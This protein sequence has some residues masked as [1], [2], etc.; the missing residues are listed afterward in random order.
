MPTATPSPALAPPLVRAALGD[1]GT[2][3]GG[4]GEPGD[5]FQITAVAYGSSG[6][7]VARRA[8]IRIG[9]TANGRG[10]RVL[11]WGNAGSV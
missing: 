7:S 3:V 8:V 5:V 4:A 10:W 9:Y 6:A 11:A 1:L 2:R